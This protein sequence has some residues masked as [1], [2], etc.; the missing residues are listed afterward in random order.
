[1]NKNFIYF[2]CALSLFLT[3][4]VQTMSEEPP[5][6]YERAS[7]A[8]SRE[9]I[10]QA[11]TNNDVQ[12]VQELI[13]KKEFK[14]DVNKEKLLHLAAYYGY[15]SAIPLLIKNGYDA[16]INKIHFNT[17]AP[18][19]RNLVIVQIPIDEY[20]T[21]L[22]AAVCSRDEKYIPET[23]ELLLNLGA[24][25][26]SANPDGFTPLHT[27]VA[28]KHTEAIKI[29]VEKAP[30]S[31]NIPD[32]EG[33][34][35]L[36]HAVFQGHQ[37]DT[38][39]LLLS[40]GADPTIVPSGCMPC[41]LLDKAVAQNATN[42]GSV[43]HTTVA[44]LLIH[45]FARVPYHKEPQALSQDLKETC[46]QS[47]SKVPWRCLGIELSK[48]GD[49]AIF[50]QLVN[51]SIDNILADIN[52]RYKFTNNAFN[53]TRQ[54]TI[55]GKPLPVHPDVPKILANLCPRLDRLGHI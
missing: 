17:W 44:T 14:P 3:S 21:P 31:I 18:V 19:Y 39:R 38:I 48:A 33:A 46:K 24:D 26:R 54:R 45:T 42:W 23:I 47:F 9:E 4:A 25:P 35:P 30:L 7:I 55:T 40:W 50:R 29:L 8:K 52:T 12:L 5:C 53:N 20:W 13:L 11:A 51:R 34:T 10:N 1:M 6:E 37:D 16:D 15:L 36:C 49:E 41:R 28:R 27:A 32:N 22:H 2:S 43:Y